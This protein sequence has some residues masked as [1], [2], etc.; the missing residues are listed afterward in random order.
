MRR[1]YGAM[2]DPIKKIIVSSVVPSLTEDF[3]IYLTKIFKVSKQ[4]STKRFLINSNQA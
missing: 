2:A 1:Y 4:D 3:D